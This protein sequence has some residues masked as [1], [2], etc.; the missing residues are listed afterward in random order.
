MRI[1]QPSDA[2]RDPDGRD[3]IIEVKT[4]SLALAF[5]LYATWNAF[6]AFE[7]QLRQS[8]GTSLQQRSD[9]SIGA[10]NSAYLVRL[11]FVPMGEVS[12]PGAVLFFQGPDAAGKT[13]ELDPKSFT[14]ANAIA[15]DITLEYPSR[16]LF[17]FRQIIYLALDA[18]MHLL[19]DLEALPNRAAAGYSYP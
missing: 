2:Y 8:M 19:A 18:R 9:F 17:R 5:R 3:Y 6:A 16:D 12:L 10:A 1:F 7:T 13:A 15:L 4:D 11:N 14:A